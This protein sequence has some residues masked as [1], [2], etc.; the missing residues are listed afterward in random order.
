MTSLEIYFSQRRCGDPTHLEIDLAWALGMGSW[1]KLAMGGGGAWRNWQW[2]GKG[3]ALDY[4]SQKRLSC[5]CASGLR[6]GHGLSLD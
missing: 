3:F 2:R 4:F 5:R 6:V 1:E